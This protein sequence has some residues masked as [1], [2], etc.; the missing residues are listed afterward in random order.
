MTVYVKETNDFDT[1]SLT[2]N[3]VL[4]VEIK[5]LFLSRVEPKTRELNIFSHL[6]QC[7]KNTYKGLVL[8]KAV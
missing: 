4:E 1:R 7:L 8:F 6:S 5:K 2:V 3:H